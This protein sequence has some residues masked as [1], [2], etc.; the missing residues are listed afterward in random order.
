MR[1][2]EELVQRLAALLLTVVW[3]VVP[4]G[5]ATYTMRSESTLVVDDSR[6]QASEERA[7][8]WLAPDAPDEPV[9][10]SPDPQGDVGE[11]SEGIADADAAD[12]SA[13]AAPEPAAPPEPASDAVASASTGT[14]TRGSVSTRMTRP[15]VVLAA[16]SNDGVKERPRRQRDCEDPSPHISSI[17]AET[18]RVD[19]DIVEFYA[20]DWEALSRL[21]WVRVHENERG[22]RDGFTVRGIRC[23]TVLAQV[24]LKNH[25]TVHAVNGKPVKNLF[26]ALAAYRKFK[27]DAVVELE[28]TRDGETQLLTYYMQG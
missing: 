20:N 21:G 15:G 19:R 23:G 9:A 12:S 22:R 1:I 5:M 8:V 16:A 4:L 28:I 3:F 26:G 7:V 14:S 17:D 27:R 25:D 2:I 6:L 18:W 10:A 24:G 13:P 11:L